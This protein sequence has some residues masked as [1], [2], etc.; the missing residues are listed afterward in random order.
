MAC[1]DR[2]IFKDF[3]Y[4]GMM[5]ALIQVQSGIHKLL[6]ILSNVVILFL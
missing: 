6:N 4:G 3:A 5:K 2:R 1:L